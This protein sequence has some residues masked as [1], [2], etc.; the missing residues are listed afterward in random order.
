MCFFAGSGLPVMRLNAESWCEA[1]RE[2]LKG[3]PASYR[4]M[5]SESGHG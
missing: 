1:G 3:I 2:E 4:K 5:D